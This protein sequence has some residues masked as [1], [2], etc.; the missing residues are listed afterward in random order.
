MCGIGERDS[1]PENEDRTSNGANPTE[2]HVLV[3]WPVW[4]RENERTARRIKASKYNG[5]EGEW[6]I[7]VEV[8]IQDNHWEEWTTL[9]YAATLSAI[10]I[11]EP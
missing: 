1:T 5:F 2:E 8:R 7:I 10:T 4:N 11:T 3:E 9:G 6:Q